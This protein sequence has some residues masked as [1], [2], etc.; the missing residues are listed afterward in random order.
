MSLQQISNRS[1][2]VLGGAV[3]PKVVT[4]KARETFG[5]AKPEECARVE[6]DAIDVVAASPSVVV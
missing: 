2:Q 5:C 6:N 4:I 1:L 3:I